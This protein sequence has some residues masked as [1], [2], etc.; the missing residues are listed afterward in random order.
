LI[1]GTEM[2]YGTILKNKKFDCNDG[3]LKVN[4]YFE[5]KGNAAIMFRY[6]DDQNFYSLELNTPGQKN[7]RLMKKSEG[8]NEEIKTADI[9]FSQGV[10]YRFRIVFDEANI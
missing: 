2:N 3:L 1:V 7:M 10:W 4:V 6:Y 9:F 5:S 8:E